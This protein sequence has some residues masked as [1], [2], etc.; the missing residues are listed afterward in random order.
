[1]RHLWLQLSSLIIPI[2]LAPSLSTAV[3]IEFPEEELAKESVLPVFEGG[4]TAVKSRRVNTKGRMEAGLAAGFIF[5]EPFFNPLIYGLRL[6]YHFNEF[7]SVQ[8]SGFLKQDE[9]SSDAKEIDSD[10]ATRIGFQGVPVP[11][12]LLMVDYQL[13]PYYGKISLTKD[14]VLNMNLFGVLGAGAID[15]GGEVTWIANLG[16]GQN[17]YFTPRMAFRADLRF[18][19]YEGPNVISIP[20][21]TKAAT[22][23]LDPSAF[24]SQF[25]V[26]PSMTLGLVFLL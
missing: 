6:G 20:T 18:L 2:L 22:T 15:V 4:T 10:P 12:Y 26:S 23:K 5:N 7:S 11:K 16:F 14:T 8:V 13:T 24:D 21:Q 1:M 9:V 17:L 25:N 3:T 19:F